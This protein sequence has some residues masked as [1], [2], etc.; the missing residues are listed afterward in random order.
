MLAI[1]YELDD[2]ASNPTCGLDD[3]SVK[4]TFFMRLSSHKDLFAFG[5][6]AT[7]LC[8]YDFA[9]QQAAIEAYIK[10]NVLPGL[11]AVGVISDPNACFAIKQ[12]ED[13]VDDPSSDPFSNAFDPQYSIVDLVLAIDEKTSCP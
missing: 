6:L 5:S 3:Y 7:G 13:G 11:A 9:G 12:A 4:M 10:S 1:H 8:Y 2:I